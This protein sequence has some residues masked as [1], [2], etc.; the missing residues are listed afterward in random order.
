MR[1]LSLK[2]RL[3]AQIGYVSYPNSFEIV[4]I[5]GGF[6]AFVAALPNFCC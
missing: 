5:S 6:G 3:L 2:D 4:E 1:L